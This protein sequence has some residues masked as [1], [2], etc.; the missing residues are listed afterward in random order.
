MHYLLFYDVVP[1]YLERRAK[2]RKEHLDLCWEA[3]GRGNSSS[4]AHWPTRSMVRCCCFKVIRPRSRRGLQ[5]QTPL[6]E[7]DS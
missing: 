5:P 6:F 3:C 2:F 4:A 1:D 7:M